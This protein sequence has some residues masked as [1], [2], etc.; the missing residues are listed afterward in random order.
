MLL[1]QKPGMAGRSVGDCLHNYGKKMKQ[2]K[3]FD[4]IGFYTTYRL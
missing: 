3:N 2:T 4:A 1:I